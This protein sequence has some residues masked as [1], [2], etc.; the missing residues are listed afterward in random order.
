[1][2]KIAQLQCNLQAP[3][4]SQPPISGFLNRGSFGCRIKCWHVYDISISVGAANAAPGR[5]AVRTSAFPAGRPRPAIVR[6]RKIKGTI[7]EIWNIGTN[8]SVCTAAIGS[9]I[10]HG[11]CC[12]DIE[13]KKYVMTFT[14]RLTITL[15]ATFTAT[16]AFARGNL[17]ELTVPLKYIPQEGVHSTSADLPPA[18]LNQPAEVRVEDARKLDDLLVIGQG[19]GGD[20]K[21]FPIHAD[22]DAIA[23]IQEMVTGVGKEWSLKQEHPAPRTLVLQ[24]T[25]FYVDESNKA[26]GS[27]YGTEVKFAFTLK[28]ARGKTLA[29]G[30]GTGTAHRYGHAHSPENINEVLSDALKEAY[31]N[32]LADPGLQKAWISGA[33]SVTNTARAAESAEERLR[34]LDDLLKK[35]LITKAE[36]DKKRAEILKDM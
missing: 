2:D 32:V 30:T 5:V 4:S 16:L 22:H 27:I 29:E 18:L 1:M 33:A 9:L 13:E 6:N 20:D 10:N 15:I 11:S 23:F 7:P 19:T 12:C 25:R 28:D 3:R 24:V 14:R 35:G 31:A 8:T 26:L 34:K 17:K 36:Y 21:I